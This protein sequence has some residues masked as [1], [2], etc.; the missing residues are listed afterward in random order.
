MPPKDNKQAKVPECVFFSV[1]SFP[2]QFYPIILL[3]A[4]I[5][6][7][8]IGIFGERHMS[9]KLKLI[10]TLHTHL[11]VCWK[12][13]FCIVI[14]ACIMTIWAARWTGV[15]AKEHSIVSEFQ[16]RQSL[17]SCHQLARDLTCLISMVCYRFKARR[18]LWCR[19]K[20]FRHS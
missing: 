18:I 8:K 1:R 11:A 9:S 17:P 2:L 5:L 10:A 7:G 15:I 20:I 6:R 3:F 16:L 4:T 12:Q 19:P 13:Y 14:H